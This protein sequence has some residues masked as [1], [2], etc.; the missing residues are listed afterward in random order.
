MPFVI[1]IIGSSLIVL[2]FT[3]KVLEVAHRLSDVKKGAGNK[4][5]AIGIISIITGL[6]I[7]LVVLD[8]PVN[9]R[10]AMMV[11][12]LNIV[13]V[14]VST[15]LQYYLTP[16]NEKVLTWGSIVIIVAGF[17]LCFIYKLA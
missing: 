1:F 2:G 4:L 8:M 7:A 5:R 3:L 15:L 17:V 16:K 13:A 9:E 14:G 11:A 10:N 12:G 6:L